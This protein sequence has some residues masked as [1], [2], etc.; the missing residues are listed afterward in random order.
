[1]SPTKNPAVPAPTRP[2][3]ADARA[4][5][6]T[7]IRDYLLSQE[8]QIAAAL[9]AFMNPTRFLR[10]AFTEFSKTPDL[11]DCTT[12][13]LLGALIQCAQ[14]GLEPGAILG[15]AY[16]VPFRN[17]K[18]NVSEVTLIVGY[19]GLLMLARRSG[20][21][22]TIHA[23]L[24][25]EGD[26]FAY[27]YGSDPMI[28]HVPAAA[29]KVLDARTL[30]PGGAALVAPITHAYAAC[31]MK[32]GGVQFE[33]MTL[34]EIEAHRDRYAHVSADS[35]WTTNFPEMALKTVLR[36][37]CRLL[38][39]SPEMQRAITLDAQARHAEPQDL[40]A[41]VGGPPD[42]EERE[43]PAPPREPEAPSPEA[44][45]EANVL[46]A[47]I[48]TTMDAL[49][50]S[51]EERVRAIK[52]ETG[53]EQLGAASLDGLIQLRDTLANQ[54]RARTAETAS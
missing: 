17:R 9:P 33:V 20:E 49:K 34:A 37:L 43:T 3:A 41:L 32:D 35:A 18:R 23:H 10:V 22:S 54:L 38:P 53:E 48:V 28:E 24:V 2:T 11:Y 40:A 6:I 16:L 36:R 47:G 30:A 13:S 39:Q 4:G 25:H 42:P 45:A 44:E 19:R 27:R 50:L 14:L 8:K 15:H 1:M 7:T 5:R 31:R 29:A 12:R 51:P 46:R 26:A 21:I 52:H